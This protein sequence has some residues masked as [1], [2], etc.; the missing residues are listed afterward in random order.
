MH[1][2]ATREGIRVAAYTDDTL[3]AWH[4][5]YPELAGASL[6]IAG[7]KKGKRTHKS[8]AFFGSLFTL[9]AWW[10]DYEFANEHEMYVLNGRDC[11]ITLESMQKLEPL[12]EQLGVRAIY[13]HEM[14][15]VEPFVRAQAR[16]LQ[17]DEPLR[18]SRIEAIE[19]RVEDCNRTLNE[20]VLPLLQARAADIPEERRHL[21]FKSKQCKCCGGGKLARSA[22]WRCAGF[23]KK[24][25]KRALTESGEMLAPCRACA[26]AGKTCWLKFNGGSVDQKRVLLYD[27]LKLPKRYN[28]GALSTDEEALKGLLAHVA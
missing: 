1:F 2:L 5:C 27:L 20:L 19:A 10:K 4:A 6:D 17:V 7:K 18:L 23:V 16:G 22:C 9:D 24:P 15:L 11:C 12:I 14:A 8:L 21:F 26:G 28:D 3:V 13:E 25:G